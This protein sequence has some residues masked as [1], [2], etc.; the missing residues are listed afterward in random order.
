[1]SVAAWPGGYGIFV[2]NTDGAV[3]LSEDGGDSFTCIT[4]TLSP[5]SKGN[6][7]VPL[8]RAAA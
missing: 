1:M 6:H 5:I 2:G 3:H 7:F 4:D 8:R